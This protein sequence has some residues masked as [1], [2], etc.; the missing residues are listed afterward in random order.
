MPD[1]KSKRGSADR[2]RVAGGETYEKKY[3]A[4]KTGLTSAQVQDLIDKVGNTREKLMK[5]ASKLKKKK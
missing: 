2:R 1:N 5:A 4:S 3:F